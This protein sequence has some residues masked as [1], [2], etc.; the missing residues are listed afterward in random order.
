[1]LQAERSLRMYSVLPY[2]LAKMVAELPI[3]ALFPNIFGVI[4]YRMTGLH[5]KRDRQGARV[6]HLRKS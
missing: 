2:F 1:M 3:S 5:P 6:D 4:L